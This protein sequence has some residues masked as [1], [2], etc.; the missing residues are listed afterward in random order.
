MQGEIAT[1][2]I[3]IAGLQTKLKLLESQT[4]GL[5]IRSPISGVIVGFDIENQLNFRPVDRGAKLLTVFDP[6]SEWELKLDVPENRVGHLTR[7][8]EIQNRG[9]LKVSF[10]MATE[11]AT[12]F[13]AQFTRLAKRADISQ[14]HGMTVQATATVQSRMPD[15]SKPGNEV[16]ARIVCENQPLWYVMFEDVVDFLYRYVVP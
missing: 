9:P 14:E 4:Q 7:T 8:M 6:S 2:E 16:Y 10:R 11:I 3:E 12:V 1:T 5:T 15:S 13:D